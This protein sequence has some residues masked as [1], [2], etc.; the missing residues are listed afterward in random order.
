M[1]SLTAARELLDVVH[2]GHEKAGFAAR[3]LQSS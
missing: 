3:I 2:E 1:N